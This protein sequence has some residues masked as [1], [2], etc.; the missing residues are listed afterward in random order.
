MKTDS[1]QNIVLIQK[2][3]TVK[4]N[5]QGVG[6]CKRTI[7]LGSWQEEPRTC[8]FVLENSVLSY[9]R[10]YIATMPP[11]VQVIGDVDGKTDIM[12]APIYLLI[13]SPDFNLST[14]YRNSRS[15][16]P[17]FLEGL[18]ERLRYLTVDDIQTKIELKTELN[19]LTNSI[20]EFYEQACTLR[21]VSTC[22]KNP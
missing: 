15:D 9:Y 18:K 8:I 10:I 1:K 12:L 20:V 6:K 19:H 13:D 22:C 4:S 21:T 16:K 3:Y 2:P 14:K 11:A 17:L 5:V 7:F